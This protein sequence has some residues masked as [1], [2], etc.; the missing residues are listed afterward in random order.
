[1]ARVNGNSLAQWLDR[2]ERLHPAEI[3]LGLE[4]VGRVAC[5]L[6]V[7]TP[8]ARV[9]TVA[10]T[11]GKGSVCCLLE[12]ILTAAGHRVG[13]YT[14]PH[15]QRFNERIRIDGVEADDNAIREAFERIE[16]AR[17]STSLTYFEFGTL[18]A[19]DLFMRAGL[20]VWVLEVG[21]GGRLDATNVIDADVAVVTSVGIDHVEWLGDDRDDVGREKAGIARR[22]RPIIIGDVAP[23]E[24]LLT[25]V[26]RAGAEPVRIGE[27]FDCTLEGAGWNWVGP[28]GGHSGLPLPALAGGYQVRNAAIALAALYHAG[29]PCQRRALEQGL[30]DANVPGRFQILPGPVETILDVAHNPDAAA[31]LAAAL[32]ERTCGGRTLAVI[33]MYADKD[34]DG[35]IGHLAEVVDGWC[36]A[37]LHG[38]RGRDAASLAEIVHRLELDLWLEAA[39]PLAAWRGARELAMA[40]DRIVVLGS[41]V[42]VAQV[43]AGMDDRP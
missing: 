11:N 38:P 14:S 33:A 6:G 2:I 21:L 35:V 17:G 3:E 16:R 29:I 26:E 1:M 18:A 30:R 31:T 19:L 39:E 7:T 36:V 34:A 28:D 4:R 10:G 9:I 23:P 20:D 43:A 37:A 32:H 40:G 42:T 13:L 8:A 25:A 15:L 27:V 41:F 12:S 22:G 24:G 5:A